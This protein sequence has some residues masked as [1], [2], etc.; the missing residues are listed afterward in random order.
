VQSFKTSPEDIPAMGRRTIQGYWDTSKLVVGEYD[1]NV[2]LHF[3]DTTTQKTYPAS[4]SL[5]KLIVRTPTGQVSGTA[6]G[7]GSSISSTLILLLVILI[8]LNVVGFIIMKKSFGKR[9][10]K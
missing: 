8:I 9:S 2:L 6:D 5:D 10:K 4:V 1:L 3:E 7:G